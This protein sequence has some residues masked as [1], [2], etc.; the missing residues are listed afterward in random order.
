MLEKL[1]KIFQ[2]DNGGKRF[3][4]RTE[5][6]FDF[7]PFLNKNFGKISELLNVIRNEN[8]S[9]HQELTTN[10][11]NREEGEFTYRF[12]S[13]RDRAYG[14]LKVKNEPNNG[15]IP[16]SFINGLNVNLPG[17]IE[18]KSLKEVADYYSSQRKV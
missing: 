8:P 4:V 11:E 14:V 3:V 17:G 7:R 6:P 2:R 16:V 13:R 1:S 12:F 5:L 10:F 9:L 18:L 15:I